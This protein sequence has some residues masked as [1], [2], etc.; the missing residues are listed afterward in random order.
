MSKLK[1][2]GSIKPDAL[3]LRYLRAYVLGIRDGWNQPFEVS[4]SYNVDHLYRA[5][6]KKDVHN[7]HDAGINLGQW[8]R[9]PFNH[10]QP[11]EA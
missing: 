5:G 4:T 8:L 2:Y 3:R 7:T 11:E 6:D 1:P 10:E 9:S